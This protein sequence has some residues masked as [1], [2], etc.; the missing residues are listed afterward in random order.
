M[1]LAARIAFGP[2]KCGDRVTRLFGRMCSRLHHW[3]KKG[4]T[5]TSGAVSCCIG[6]C[7]QAPLTWNNARAEFNVLVDCR[8]VW[9]SPKDSANKFDDRRKHGQA[10]GLHLRIMPRTNSK[11]TPPGEARGGPVRARKQN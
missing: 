4:S 6:T 5:S 11:A 3:V 1:I 8:S 7:A 2:T 10:R 9:R